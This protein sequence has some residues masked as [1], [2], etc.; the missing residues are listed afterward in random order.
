MKKP[1]AS[2]ALSDLRENSVTVLDRVRRSEEPLRLTRRGK[3]AAILWS[4]DE[5]ERS[6]KERALLR[7]LVQ[8]E[9]EI[10]LGEG[11]DLD[12]VLAEAEA[13]LV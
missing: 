8:G 13:L 12:T 5:F 11:Y 4:L 7:R 6:E 10:A 3:P 2:V 9:H 1:Q